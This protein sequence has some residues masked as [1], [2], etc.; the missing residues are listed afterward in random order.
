[1][2]YHVEKTSFL[3]NKLYSIYVNVNRLRSIRKC[4]NIF[5]AIRGIVLM[6]MAGRLS[7]SI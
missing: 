3:K 2:S 4:G 7:L 6:T 1:M 5:T